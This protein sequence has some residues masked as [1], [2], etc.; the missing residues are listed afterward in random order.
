M[1]FL[2]SGLAVYLYD[3]MNKAKERQCIREGIDIDE[4]GEY[5]I[6]GI[7]SPLFR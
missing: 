3:R 7:D 5:A 4:K 1:A 2:S 6:T